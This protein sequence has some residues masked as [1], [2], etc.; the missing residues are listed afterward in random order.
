MLFGLFIPFERTFAKESTTI[1]S[2]TSVIITESII[3]DSDKE[4][5]GEDWKIN[6]PQ[7]SENSNFFFQLGILIIFLSASIYSFYLKKKEDTYGV[8]HKNE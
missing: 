3:T 6:F 4:N 7:T 5:S 1:R 8:K 2:N